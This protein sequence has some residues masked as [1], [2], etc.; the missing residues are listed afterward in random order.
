MPLIE[1]E[2][3][4]LEIVARDLSRSAEIAEG[5]ARRQSRLT[6]YAAAAG[7]QSVTAAIG[8]FLNRW[9]YGCGCLVADTRHLAASVE[10]AAARYRQID[11]GVAEASVIE[12]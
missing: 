9:S 11:A 8:S 4:G 1:V 10:D 3:A 12:R 2:P 5:V 7:N 6:A